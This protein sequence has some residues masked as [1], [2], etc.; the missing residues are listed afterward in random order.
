MN[1]QEDISNLIFNLK[2]LSKIKEGQKLK[3]S[4]GVISIENEGLSEMV[5]R[6]ISGDSRTTTLLKIQEI[7]KTAVK[8]ARLSIDCHNFKLTN[9]S[10]NDLTEDELRYHLELKEWSKK[11]I[12]LN[13]NNDSFLNSLVLLLTNSMTGIK[14]LQKTYQSD[15]SFCSKLDVENELI[16]RTIKQIR[17]TIDVTE[18][19]HKNKQYDISIK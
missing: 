14:E 1:L 7:F 18:K 19:E 16:E 3:V 4:T 5:M 17:D 12:E 11:E 8:Y 10:V 6:K 13:M 15:I 2:V 9:I